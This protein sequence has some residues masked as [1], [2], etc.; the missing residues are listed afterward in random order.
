MHGLEKRKDYVRKLVLTAQECAEAEHLFL[1]A[2]LTEYLQIS[3]CC[4]MYH[5]SFSEKRLHMRLHEKL[6]GYLFV[7]PRTHLYAVRIFLKSFRKG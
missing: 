7:Q 1:N 5:Y 3:A 4:K 2:S 6:K